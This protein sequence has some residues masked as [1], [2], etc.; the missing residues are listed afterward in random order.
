MKELTL[1]DER[2][3]PN[4][5]NPRSGILIEHIARYVFAK[6]IIKGKILDLACGV[7][8][9]VP[10]LFNGSQNTLVN[11]YIGVDIDQE[12]IEY[13]KIHYSHPQAKFLTGDACDSRIYQDLGC[14]DS[15]ISFETIEHIEE[16][17]DFIKNIITLLKPGG[18]ALISTPFGHGRDIK[19]SNP[20]HFRQYTEEEFKALLTPFK[21]F[22]MYHQIDEYIEEPIPGKKYYLMLAVCNL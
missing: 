20:F 8:Y 4:A 9:A 7:G 14:F 5:M 21:K 11:E 18:T 2:V 22:K 15:I 17:F 1:T 12:C 6:N 13:A 10:I 19:C 3:I 16:D